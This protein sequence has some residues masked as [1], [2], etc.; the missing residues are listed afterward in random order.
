MESYLFK[1]NRFID[2]LIYDIKWLWIDWIRY[3]TTKQKILHIAYLI[4]FIA[5]VWSI[6]S[7]FDAFDSLKEK[8]QMTN[9]N[10]QILE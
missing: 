10:L 7:Y 6:A 2:N 1:L 4:S 5:M 8:V 3:T 9:K